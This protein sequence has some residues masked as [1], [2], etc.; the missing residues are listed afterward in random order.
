[1][2]ITAE[3]GERLTLTATRLTQI[4]H[5]S[6]TNYPFHITKADLKAALKND[7]YGGWQKILVRGHDKY[8]IPNFVYVKFSSNGR[9]GCENFTEATFNKILK[10]MGLKKPKG[11]RS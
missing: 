7:S 5:H 11:G 4:D 2:I 10:T 8:G 3:N 1:M 9:I 6:T